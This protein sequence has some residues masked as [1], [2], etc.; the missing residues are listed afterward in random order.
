MF[1]KWHVL[2]SPSHPSP[3]PDSYPSCRMSISG[4]IVSIRLFGFV[5]NVGEV[6]TS[7]VLAVVHGGHE[8]TSTALGLRALTPEALDLAVAVDLVVLEDRE[9]GLLALVL[10]LLG[11]GVHLLLALLGSTTEA[12]DQVESRLLL[13]VVIRKSAAILK[14]LAGEDQT[15]LVRRNALLVLDLALDIAV[16]VLAG[17]HVRK[18]RILSYSMVCRH[19]SSCT[20][21]IVM[22]NSRR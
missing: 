2:F 7:A 17:L 12:E 20:K 18:D 6:A 3:L 11:G 10:D 21:G 15:L 9:L 4:R 1:D 19:V 22:V 5:E 14:L 13:D 8:D 16:G